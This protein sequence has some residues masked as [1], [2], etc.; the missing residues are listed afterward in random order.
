M[1]MRYADISDPTN[2]S[3][4]AMPSLT[5]G[6]RPGSGGG[7]KEDGQG[8]GAGAGAN[9]KEKERQEDPRIAERK[10]LDKEDFDPDACEQS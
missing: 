3:V 2:P 7:V 4:P 9:K 8:G 5:I 6:A 10:M 1:S